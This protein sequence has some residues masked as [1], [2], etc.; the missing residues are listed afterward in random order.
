MK[1]RNHDCEIENFTSKIKYSDS[2]V[3][4]SS[5]RIIF[6]NEDFTKESCAQLSALLIYYDHINL[7]EEITIYIN[8]S[9]GD[10]DGLLQILDTID[11]IEV[12][13]K[14][15]CLG[16]AYSSGCILLSAGTNGRRFAAKSSSMMIHG[17]QCSF[18][19]DGDDLTNS[20]IHF[21]SISDM[22]DVIMKILAKNTNHSVADMKKICERDTW[23]TAQEALNLG[24]IDNIL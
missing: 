19:I 21:K 8:S 18:P 6:M 2:Y 11:M 9:G 23:M 15:V 24:F 1:K 12:P 7:K 14:T 5:N 16:R 3:N 17:I 10:A 20:K 13:I 22:N 4:L